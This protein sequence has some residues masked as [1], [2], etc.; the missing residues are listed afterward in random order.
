MVLYL[1]FTHFLKE[2]EDSMC[3][4]KHKLGNILPTPAHLRKTVAEPG[5]SPMPCVQVRVIN[6][7]R[8]EGGD[9]NPLTYFI[10]PSVP[11][12]WREYMRTG[13][14]NWRP[15]LE[16]AGLGSEAIRAVLP[17]EDAWPDD[18]DAGDIRCAAQASAL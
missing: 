12:E 2:N 15:A 16:A 3:A 5:P 7:R 8:I 13:V 14:H 9:S 4:V 6:K 18:Y 11:P 1:S 10:D 17:G